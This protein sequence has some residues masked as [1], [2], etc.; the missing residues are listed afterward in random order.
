MGETATGCETEADHESDAQRTS[1]RWWT[2][3]T[4]GYVALLGAA[5][6]IRGAVIPSLRQAFGVPDW[7]LGLVAPAGTLGFLT[8]VMLVGAVAG[9]LDTRR[10]LL[11]GVVGT[12]ISI[13]TMGLVPSFVLFLAALL[14]RGVF[15][16]VGRGTDRPLL[17]HLYPNQRGRLFGYY[18]MMWAVGAVF[19][20]LLVAAAVA[21]NNWRYAY[22][23]LG[24]AFVPLTL[25]VLVLPTPDV[26]GGDDP[27]DLAELRRIGRRPEVLAMAVG[28]FLSAGFEG[29]LFTW[30]TTFAQGRL[31]DALATASLS[32]LL[33]GYIPGRFL[34]GRFSERFG[35]VRLS[36]ALTALTIP[37]FAYTFFLADGYG[38]L[39]GY[40]GIGLT[41]SGIYPT[42]LAYGTEAV[43]EHSAPVNAMAAVTSSAGIAAVPAAMGFVI[44]GSDIVRAMRLLAIPL[45]ALL[46]LLLVAW[47]VAGS[48]QES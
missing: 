8:V 6:Q 32:V 45:C 15:S 41:L 2:V 37:I 12:G 7:Q 40:F 46:A 19:G 38:L 42:M 13:F 17:S 23:A 25:L 22:F 35:Y 44:S 31:S 36:V 5:L 21:A 29:G 24:L 1:R 43:P 18:D 39:A 34:S 48:A 47:F 11:I 4:F 30:L 28:L 26:E 27:L 3:V 9:R 14:G 10:L 33:A 20:P 16:G